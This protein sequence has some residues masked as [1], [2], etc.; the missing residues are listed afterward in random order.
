M[1]IAQGLGRVSHG[2][3]GENWISHVSVVVKTLM[4]GENG[5]GSRVGSLGGSELRLENIQRCFESLVPIPSDFAV[6]INA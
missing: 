6:V 4:G 3:C 2:L 5:G 1:R